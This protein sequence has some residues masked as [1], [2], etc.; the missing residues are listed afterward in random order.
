MFPL[1]FMDQKP[2]YVCDIRKPITMHKDE[3]LKEMYEYRK[4]FPVNIIPHVSD[5]GEVVDLIH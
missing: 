3:I 4:E 2:E 1:E 5:T